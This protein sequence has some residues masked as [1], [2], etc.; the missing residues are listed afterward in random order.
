MKKR[1]IA[2]KVVFAMLLQ[3]LPLPSGI[4]AG[5]FDMVSES[6]A[7]TTSGTVGTINWK[8]TKETAKD[9]LGSG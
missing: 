7:A 5:M 4:L 8:L 9:G 6:Q 2:I 3:I 1:R